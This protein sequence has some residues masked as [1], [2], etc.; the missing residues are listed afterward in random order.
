M[1]TMEVYAN[2]GFHFMEDK[3]I[4]SITSSKKNGH[5]PMSVFSLLYQLELFLSNKYIDRSTCEIP[6]LTQFVL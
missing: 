4:R 6:F 1:Q 5:H 3:L 2:Y